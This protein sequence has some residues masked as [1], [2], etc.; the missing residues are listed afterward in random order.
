MLLHPSL[1]RGGQ[2]CI[3]KR[4]RFSVMDAHIFDRMPFGA[5]KIA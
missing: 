2:N 4:L 1:R 3:E 5:K